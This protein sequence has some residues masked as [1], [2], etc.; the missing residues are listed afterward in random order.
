MKKKY[1]VCK[2]IQDSLYVA[3]NEI[4][5]CCQR[6]FHNGEIRGDAKLLDITEGVTP[7]AENI[8]IS[9]EK[10]FN[11]LEAEGVKGLAQGYAN[12]HM[13]P[14]YQKKIAYGET[15]FP[16]NSEF[17][18]RDISYKKG[19]CPVAERLHDKTFLG[20]EMCLHDLTEDDCDLVIKSFQKVWQN[21]DQL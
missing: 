7:T 4:R 13:L 5:A 2:Y 20:Y 21:L 18:S 9:R 6:F 15:G 16:W 17:N 1:K 3:P 8:K 12:I 19:I 11:A 14:M 10:I